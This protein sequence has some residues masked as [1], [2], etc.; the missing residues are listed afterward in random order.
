VAPS[1]RLV[2]VSR[3]A[4]L[5]VGRHLTTGTSAQMFAQTHWLSY[6]HLSVKFRFCGPGV[7]CGEEA[8]AKKVVNPLF[9][10]RPENF[11][12]RQEIQPN[13]DL[14]H[15]IKWPHYIQVQWQRAILYK[16]LKVP[17]LQTRT[18]QEKQPR[19]LAQAEKKAAG[20][21]NDPTE[22]LSVLQAGVNTVISLVEN[23]KTQ[24]VTIV[25]DVDPIELLLF[26]PALCRKMRLPYCPV[27]RKVNLEDKGALAKLAEAIRTNYSD[28]YEEI[29]DHWGGKVVGP[30]SGARNAILEKA[31]AKELATKM[32]PMNTF[33][34]SVQKMKKILQKKVSSSLN[35]FAFPLS[36]SLG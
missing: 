7:C 18:K 1:K 9:E 4:F 10:K 2:W 29:H 23:K 19:S 6:L 8:G 26:L 36:F 28:R 35:Y 11:G 27:K 22:R 25:H 15:F 3:K 12:I 13:R 30:K 33:E 34:F 31:K 17:L 21:E 14:T 16:Q 5:D 20:K 24:L 32:G